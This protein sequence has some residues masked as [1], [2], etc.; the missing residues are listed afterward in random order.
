[1]SEAQLCALGEDYDGSSP[2][3]FLIGAPAL[4][5]VALR[6]ESQRVSE[7][8]EMV[9]LSGLRHIISSWN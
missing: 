8:Y 7:P 1:M 9:V 3:A 4:W 6:I 5:S 2:V